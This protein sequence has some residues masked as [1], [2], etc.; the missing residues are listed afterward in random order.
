MHRIQHIVDEALGKLKDSLSEDQAEEVAKVIEAAV[1]RGIL[2][3]QHRAVDACNELGDAE[4]DLAHK[5]RTAIRQKNDA[6]IANL[7]A[8]R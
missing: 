1:I 8:M 4:Q 3:G 6:L 5:I 7:S 2:E